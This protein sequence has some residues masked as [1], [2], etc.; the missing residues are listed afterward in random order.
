MRRYQQLSLDEREKMARLRQS[1][2]SIAEI[3]L[4]L[5]RKCSTVYRELKRNQTVKG[6]Y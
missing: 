5:G 3:S 6:D 1:E 2:S 4:A